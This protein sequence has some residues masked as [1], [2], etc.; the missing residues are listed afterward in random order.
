MKYRMNR[1]NFD[2]FDLLVYLILRY[3][4]SHDRIFHQNQP[5]LMGQWGW[6]W[7]KIRSFVLSFHNKSFFFVLWTQTNQILSVEHEPRSARI[8]FWIRLVGWD[9]IIVYL[10]VCR[11]WD[12]RKNIKLLVWESLWVCGFRAN[13]EC[14]RFKSRAFLFIITGKTRTKENTCRWV[15]V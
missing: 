12:T 3:R 13:L 4:N 8:F 15:S 14:L 10:L 5:H 1:V 9:P 7:W 6:F 2:F 11:S